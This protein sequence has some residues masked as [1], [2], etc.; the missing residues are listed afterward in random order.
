MNRMWKGWRQTGRAEQFRVHIVNY[1][2]DL[3][4]LSRG[5]EETHSRG[6]YTFRTSDTTWIGIAAI[7]AA[8]ATRELRLGYRRRVSR[9]SIL[10]SKAVGN[11]PSHPPSIRIHS[12]PPPSARITP[13][14]KRI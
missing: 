14:P 1:A 8:A 10:T 3:V 6:V 4:I 5:I 13:C 12:L 9:A 11:F 7:F 2:D